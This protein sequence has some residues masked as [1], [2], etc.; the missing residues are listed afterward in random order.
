ME[1][2]TQERVVFASEPIVL[3]G[4][5]RHCMGILALRNPS[6]APIKL[7][8]LRFRFASPMGPCFEG[9]V[10]EIRLA[11]VLCPLETKHLRIRMPLPP[12]T[13]P[14]EYRAFCDGAEGACTP[15][16]IQVLESRRTQLSPPSFT[17]EAQPGATFNVQ[18]SVG[19][20]GNTPVLIPTR[21]AVELH[22]DERGWPHQFHEAIKARGKNGHQA[23][24]DSFVKKMA[25]Q[26][27]P[28]GRAKVLAGAGPLAPQQGRVVEMSISL[29]KRLRGGRRYRAVI[30][31]VDASLRL[32]LYTTA[33]VAPAP[34]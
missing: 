30:R 8:R 21:A 22:A 12:G 33:D 25:R 18:V 15:I 1:L 9:D 7:N 29:P 28:V 27:P 13:P 3:I 14:G 6:I 34:G 11:A 5:P 24:L 16:S 20:L 17:C 32:R 23:F 4:D 19:N 26:E 2:V 10:L 31:L